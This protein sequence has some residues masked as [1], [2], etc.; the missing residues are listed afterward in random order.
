MS[1]RNSLLTISAGTLL[2]ATTLAHGIILYTNT[3]PN[4]PIGQQSY[5]NPGPPTLVLDDVLIDNALNPL[6]QPIEVTRIMF[7]ITRL[8]GAVSV[9]ISPYYAE[10]ADDGPDPDQFA[11]IIGVPIPAATPVTLPARSPSAPE[12][13]D[14][15]TF[16]NGITPL[17]SLNPNFTDQPTF[18]E[19][20][21]GITFSN[22]DFTNGWTLSTENPNQD[23]FWD[24]DLVA[25]TYQT[26]TFN[27][28]NKGTLYMVVEGNI[29]PEPAAAGVILLGALLGRRRRT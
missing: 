5:D 22:A 9:T 24:W 7:G 28:P 19:F 21:L 4:R 23:G 1:A 2:C 25:G 29:I 26:H 17:F 6:M 20:L 16:G 10:V 27:A 13:I 11:D 18:G 12:I 3:S 15:V 8:P 14:Q